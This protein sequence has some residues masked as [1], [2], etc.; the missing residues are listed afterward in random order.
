MNILNFMLHVDVRP[1]KYV[2]WLTNS[3]RYTFVLI[4]EGFI[5]VI[6]LQE[7]YQT[8]VGER[9]VKL[10][11]GQKQRVAI[12]RAL[13]MD[14]EILLLDEVNYVGEIIIKSLYKECQVQKLVSKLTFHP[15]IRSHCQLQKQIS[16]LYGGRGDLMQESQLPG[17]G[18]IIFTRSTFD[19]C[20]L[21]YGCR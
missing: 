17:L 3:Q 5:V 18:E 20:M 8:E 6:F 7:G 13:L 11:G 19:M 14:P 1:I 9:G 10:S 4:E 2:E 12:A 16:L 15:L 21:L